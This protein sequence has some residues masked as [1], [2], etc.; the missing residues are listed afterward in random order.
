MIIQT[1]PVQTP[2]Y[3]LGVWVQN[4]GSAIATDSDPNSAAP[5][6]ARI[7]KHPGSISGS[8]QINGGT[9]CSLRVACVGGTS[10]T[11]I[12]YWFDDT[13]SL[14]VPFGAA[15]ATLTTA[16]ANQL[17]FNIGNVSG[18]R[19]FARVVA[20]TGVTAFGYGLV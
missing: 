17:A 15:A 8:V 18:S 6:A 10:M 4:G 1:A 5:A 7:I 2:S 3:T 11:T 12:V 9:S 14:W 16:G 20:N 13:L 19:W